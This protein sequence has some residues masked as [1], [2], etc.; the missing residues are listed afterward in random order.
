[1]LAEAKEIGADAILDVRFTTSYV[2]GGAAEILATG[3]AV[4]LEAA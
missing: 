3:N 4:T 1:M 2:M